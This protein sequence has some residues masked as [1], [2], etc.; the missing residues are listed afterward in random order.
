MGRLPLRRALYKETVGSPKACPEYAEGFPSYPLEYM[1][2]SKTAVV[3]CPLA[4]SQ[5]GLLPARHRSR[6]G[7]AGGLSLT[8]NRVS[9]HPL[10]ADL[11]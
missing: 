10:S 6:L 1:P 9:F 5:A 7:E 4:I 8:L 2:W 11:S 3:S